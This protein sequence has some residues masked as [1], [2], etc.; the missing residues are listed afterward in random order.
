MEHE[1]DRCTATIA[2]VARM[3]VRVMFMPP[4]YRAECRPE[5]RK[6]RFVV[7]EGGIKVLPG[8]RAVRELNVPGDEH[9]WVAEA[10]RE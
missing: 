1:H 2:V 6:R 8:L 5:Q 4:M 10:W 9:R 7:Q 3:M